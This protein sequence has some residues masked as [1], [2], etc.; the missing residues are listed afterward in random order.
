MGVLDHGH[1]VPVPLELVQNF[2]QLQDENKFYLFLYGDLET[3][4]TAEKIF[5]FLRR[6]AAVKVDYV[7][8]DQEGYSRP[9]I[10]PVHK[11]YL[12]RPIWW[13]DILL[14]SFSYCAAKCRFNLE[15]L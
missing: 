4:G 2:N 13:V 3:G 12:Q 10:S 9:F 7:F 11:S 5:P 8:Q 14:T 15:A 1:A 6:N